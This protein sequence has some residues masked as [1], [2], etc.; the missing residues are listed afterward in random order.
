LKIFFFST[1]LRL[2]ICLISQK[3]NPG[4]IAK[5]HDWTKHV[6]YTKEAIDSCS[7]I[8]YNETEIL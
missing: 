8:N 1:L 2:E 4:Y 6:N 3:E 7:K 5:A